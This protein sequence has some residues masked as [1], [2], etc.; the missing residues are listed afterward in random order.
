MILAVFLRNEGTHLQRLHI[1]QINYRARNR[2][3]VGVGDRPLHAARGVLALF[4][5]EPRGCECHQQEHRAYRQETCH[6]IPPLLRCGRGQFSC[7]WPPNAYFQS[8][9]ASSSSSSSMNS[10]SSSSSSSASSADSSSRGS[11][12]ITLRAAPQ[13]SQLIVSPS[14]TSSSST[15]IMPW[16]FGH[17][18]ISFLPKH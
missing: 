6:L 17:V 1:L 9:S 3:I 13:S 11:V 8:S 7:P 15:S 5:R 2:G 16:H 12:P 10:S 18:T 4:L 14:S